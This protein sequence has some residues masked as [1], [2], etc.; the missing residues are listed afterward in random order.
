MKKILNKKS[1]VIILIVLIILV[2]IIISGIILYKNNET[3][4]SSTPKLG[5]RKIKHPAGCEHLVS[6]QKVEE[7]APTKE[8]LKLDNYEECEIQTGNYQYEIEDLKELNHPNLILIN[9]VEEL[10]E[11]RYKVSSIPH[12]SVNYIDIDE[13]FFA[14]KSLIVYFYDG[15]EDTHVAEGKVT[16]AKKNKGI[17]NIEIAISEGEALVLRSEDLSSRDSSA[18]S[19]VTENECCFYII[20]E[21]E[22]DINNINLNITK[23]EAE[24]KEVYKDIYL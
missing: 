22:E 20:I 21:K 4:I 15:E 9:S 14:K 3:G 1:R 10:N 11:W 18:K 19:G 16:K 17:T 5:I 7:Y 6:T 13:N 23:Y 12:Y 8:F 2:I 24:I